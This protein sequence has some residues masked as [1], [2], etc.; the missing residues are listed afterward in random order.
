MIFR[1]SITSWTFLKAGY[2]TEFH[3]ELGGFDISTGCVKNG[4]PVDGEKVC[5]GSYDGGSR[6]LFKEGLKKCCKGKNMYST[7]THECCDNGD[8]GIVGTCQ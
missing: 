7:A 6:Q 8:V 1:V 4:A 3:R 2:N 5:C